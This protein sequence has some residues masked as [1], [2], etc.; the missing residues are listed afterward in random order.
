MI[1]IEDLLRKESSYEPE[2]KRLLLHEFTKNYN[3]QKI[4][5]NNPQYAPLINEI[6]KNF[7]YMKALSEAVITVCELRDKKKHDAIV[8]YQYIEQRR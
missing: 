4:I 8:D 7:A 6:T 1:K 2:E 5:L 3:S